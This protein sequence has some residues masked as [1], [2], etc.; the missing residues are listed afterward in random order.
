MAEEQFWYTCPCCGSKASNGLCYGCSNNNLPDISFENYARQLWKVVL[1]RWREG[2]KMLNREKI[3]KGLEICYSPPSKC[4]NCPYYDL[5]D[6]QSCNDV[7]CLDALALLKE[8][9]PKTIRGF[10]DTVE[11][12]VIGNCPRCDRLIVSKENDPAWFCKY[13]G[14]AVIWK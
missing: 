8:Q 6:E 7:L 2:M 3:V 13:C 11:G 4:E 10:A 14:Q 9:E 12:V 5:P 1:R